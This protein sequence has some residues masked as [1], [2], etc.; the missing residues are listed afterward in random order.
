[1]CNLVKLLRKIGITTSS[2]KAQKT[3]AIKAN[4]NGKIGT[5]DKSI[6]QG[7]FEVLDLCGT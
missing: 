3:L 7:N 5:R 2:M 4:E 6:M 1:M